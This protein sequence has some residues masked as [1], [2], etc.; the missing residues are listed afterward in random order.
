[1]T[2]ILCRHPIELAILYFALRD[3]LS[4]CCTLQVKFVESVYEYLRDHVTHYSSSSLLQHRLPISIKLDMTWK[5]TEF[6]LFCSVFHSWN[7]WDP[8]EWLTC[9][10]VASKQE[11][12]WYTACVIGSYNEM[13]KVCASASCCSS[14][15]CRGRRPDRYVLICWFQIFADFGTRHWS[16]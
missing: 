16:P 1:M 4:Y 14:W 2:Q 9:E 7:V 12:L 10:T 5:A 8:W 13:H 11:P 3:T 6:T 15:D